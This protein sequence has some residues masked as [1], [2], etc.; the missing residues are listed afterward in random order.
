MPVSSP[1]GKVND[2]PKLRIQD[3]SAALPWLIL[4][5]GAIVWGILVYRTHFQLED[6]LITYRYSSN[7]IAGNGFVFNPGERVL[8]TTTPLVTLLLALVSLPFGPHAVRE[9]ATVVM[10]IFGLLAGLA[11]YFALTKRGVS[12]AA[13]AV[14]MCFLYVHLSL[15]R[16]GIGGMETPVVLL[17]MGLSLWALGSDRPIA[18]G[19]L[20]GLIVLC[21]IDGGIW[22][23]TMMLA[24]LLRSWRKA[25]IAA[26]VA[27]L[28]AL[29]WIIFATLYFGS[30]LPNAMLAKAVVRPGREHL[31]VTGKHMLA[32]ALWYVNGTGFRGSLYLFPL[33]LAVLALGARRLLL[34]SRKDLWPI[35]AFPIIYALVMYAG[36]APR[37]EWYLLPIT[38]MCMILLGVG[39]VEVCGG[40]GGLIPAR[41][42][43][44]IA[45]TIAA[46][47]VLWY[48]GAAVPTMIR[49]MSPASTAEDQVRTEV[50]RWLK[51]NTP[52]DASV[53][54]EAIGYQ[55]YYSQRR[56]VDFAG[57]VSPKV[58][59]FKRSTALNGQVF[60]DVLRFFKPDYI[61]LRSFEVDT[62]HH[63]NGGLLFLTP[64][65]EKQFHETYREVRRF[66][67]PGCGPANL[68]AHLTL[69]RRWR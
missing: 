20:C 47:A 44:P 25:A 30:F 13:A 53:A 59:E 22:A 52:E 21:R 3:R 69:Y 38:Y 4:A 8:G 11:A 42:R 2:S 32:Y 27:L 12:V 18:V 1:H 7:I 48:C 16:T 55:G 57:L 65:R 54:M 37:F 66:H 61:V 24:L 67:G 35:V 45:V 39:V 43:T 15:I 17:L 26:L 10:P 5:F 19:V 62:N 49:H 28:V 29:P 6:A 68:L 34:Q 56:I 36:R 40:I 33:W 64:E 46:V 9:V 50:G 23:A 41:A 14:A 58:V 31:L 63:F 60:D 51:D